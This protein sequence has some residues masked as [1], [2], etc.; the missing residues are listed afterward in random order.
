M[1]SDHE[2]AERAGELLVRAMEPEDI[3][4]VMEIDRNSFPNPWPE[5]TYG[6]ELRKNP[7][8]HL[9]VVQTREPPDVIGVAGYWMVVDEAHIST[10]AV[11]PDWRRRGVGTILLAALLRQAGGAGAVCAMLEVRA[12]N[13]AAQGLYRK[14]G[15]QP[16]GRRKGYYK[17]NGEDAVLMT[18]DRL[19]GGQ[20]APAQ[21]EWK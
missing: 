3:P 1:T 4:P 6:Y 13:L 2:L 12:G 14:F 20:S 21:E 10:F 15:F 19:A 16:V 17:D 18:A 9:F 8:S 11:R 7:A 5:N